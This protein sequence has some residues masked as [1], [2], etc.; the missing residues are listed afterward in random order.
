MKF[1]LFISIF[2]YADTYENEYLALCKTDQ[3]C[4]QLKNQ[5]G[6]FVQPK[7]AILELVSQTSPDLKKIAQKLDVS[8]DAVASAIL[9][10]NSMNVQAD[11]AVQNALVALKIAPTGSVMGKKFSIGL[12]Q[13][14]I[15]PAMEAEEKIAKLLGRKPRT[16][17]EVAEK[18]LTTEGA[19]EYAAGIMRVA[20]DCYKEQGFDIKGNVPVLATV[21]N[22]GDACNRAKKAK[23]EGR[24]PQ[25][26]YFGLFAKMNQDKVKKYV[27]RTGFTEDYKEPSG[28]V[29]SQYVK[30]IQL[31]QNVPTCDKSGAGASGQFNES[32]S[33]RSAVPLKSISGY[34]RV[35]SRDVD[36]DLNSWVMIQTDKGEI[37]WVKNADLVKKAYEDEGM[38][39]GEYNPC[40]I[41]N[42]CENV[43]KSKLGK[44]YKSLDKDLGLLSANYIGEG[45][46]PG[47]PKSDNICLGDYSSPTTPMSQGG[48][49]TVDIDAAEAKKMIAELEA[50]QGKINSAVGKNT[51]LGATT[52]YLKRSLERCLDKNFKCKVDK[53]AFSNYVGLAISGKGISVYTQIRNHINNTYVNV[54]VLPAVA[55]SGQASAPVERKSSEIFNQS[56]TTA[57]L[58][59]P[60]LKDITS[61]MY[62]A[63]KK[64]DSNQNRYYSNEDVQGLNWLCSQTIRNLTK[65][66]SPN[67]GEAIRRKKCKNNPHSNDC[68]VRIGFKDGRRISEDQV[69]RAELG[70]QI[71][72]SEDKEAMDFLISQLNF[73]KNFKLSP[74]RSRYD[75]SGVCDYNP[76]KN[77]KRFDEL[78]ETGC[79]ETLLVND[80]YY[81][82]AYRSESDRKVMGYQ[83]Q[84]DTQFSIQL[85]RSCD[86]SQSDST[87]VNQ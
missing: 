68:S 3:F 17:E 25:I 65:Y 10:E 74:R 58:M 22:L 73:F 79:I 14:N 51:S 64:N 1:L 81:M 53:A 36:C 59:Y 2:C 23:A 31:F 37:G 26:N 9:A 63:F 70:D 16:Q 75:N 69:S 72:I 86:Q 30:N 8:P 67:R 19:Y 47:N 24:Q 7:Q 28:K 54:D 34:F 39:S 41:K 87:E 78:F 85:K 45:E 56:C 13:I 5:D 15:E 83:S 48:R 46:G 35:I 33:Y 43:L 82:G 55:L 11:D 77:K 62:E 80:T 38:F 52:E 29:K 42:N 71:A 76:L 66:A 12:G 50:F 40:P 44:D 4:G 6:T 32:K 18:L 21:Y 61:S 20:Q 84:E 57:G 60:E 49:S 27:E